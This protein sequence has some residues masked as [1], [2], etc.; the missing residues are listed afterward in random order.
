MGTI[1]VPVPEKTRTRGSSVMVT[2]PF[3][4]LFIHFPGS[5]RHSECTQE[6]S[7]REKRYPF[8]RG[9]VVPFFHKDLL[10]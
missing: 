8:S 3:K 6:L 2:E 7:R 9:D 1:A 10:I 5:D 4:E